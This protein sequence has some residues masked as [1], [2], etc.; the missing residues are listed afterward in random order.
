MGDRLGRQSI[1]GL[2]YDP[3]KMVVVKGTVIDVYM[4]GMDSSGGQREMRSGKGGGRRGAGRSNKGSGRGRNR[5]K[6]MKSGSLVISVRTMHG[7]FQVVLGPS[8]FLLKNGL[9]INPRD[10]VIIVGS[11]VEISSGDVVVLASIIKRGGT[12]VRIRDVNGA[13]L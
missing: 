1:S 9:R 5:G 3:A 13:A 12:S 6:K 10:K 2:R 11:R 4:P 7:I 8:R